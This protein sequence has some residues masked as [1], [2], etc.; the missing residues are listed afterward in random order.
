MSKVCEVQA[1]VKLLGASRAGHSPAPQEEAI[2]DELF[3]DGYVSCDE[4]NDQQ[5]EDTLSKIRRVSDG[6]CLDQQADDTSS[7]SVG[8]RGVPEDAS[9]VK[10]EQKI[11]VVEEGFGFCLVIPIEVSSGITVDALIDTDPS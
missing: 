11:P 1:V 4:V 3:L 8:S 9:E 7:E 10:L 6:S 2:E 5:E